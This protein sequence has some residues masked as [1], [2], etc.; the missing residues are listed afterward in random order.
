L[1]VT[2]VR[3]LFVLFLLM[4]AFILGCP[5]G[6]GDDDDSSNTLAPGEGYDIGDTLPS[7]DMTNQDGETANVHDAAGDRVLLVISAGWCE[8]C[9]LSADHAQALYDEL[10]EDF[11]FTL[12]ETLIQDE[13]Q[14]NDVSAA[15][16]QSWKDLHGLTSLDVWTDGETDCLDPFGISGELP[17][18]V[19]ADEDLVIR[20][21]IEEGYTS[22]VEQQ[23]EDAIR[24]L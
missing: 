12:W 11:G 24:D 21:I 13:W 18:F 1:E 4:P 2:T 14:G 19:I 16:L 3:A 23:V 9:G 8:P 17:V 10:N 5:N 7:C 20:E 6:G 15:Q 22:S